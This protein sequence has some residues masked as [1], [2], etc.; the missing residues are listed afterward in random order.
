MKKGDIIFFLKKSISIITAVL[1]VL[2]C[3]CSNTRILVEGTK[4]I[5]IN[6][7][8]KS[9]EDHIPLE[10]KEINEK[11]QG[12][13]KVGKPYIIDNIEYIPKLVSYYNKKGIASWYGPKFHNKL[14]ANGEIFD[15]DKISAAHKTL[16][17]PSIVKV[18]NL[19]TQKFLFIRVNDRGPFVNNRI[20]D[21]SKEAAIQLNMFKKGTEKVRVELMDT[22]PH[23]LLE[24]FLN[25]AYLEKY[26]NNSNLE[27]KVLSIKKNAFYL[28]LGAF[29]KAQNAELYLERIKGKL[30]YQLS[31]YSSIFIDNSINYL[32]KVLIG[33]YEDE[34]NAKF[35]ANKLLKL[36]YDTI[37]IILNKG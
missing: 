33:P 21:L 32:H 15:Q 30:D 5:I 10:D 37:I 29:K 19:N 28:Q 22:G 34:K 35:A 14:T 17:L 3:A 1:L 7:E 26:V 20:I 16:P 27:K 9:K 25:Q 36:G 6:D 2:L 23:L 11:T 13:Y 12:H 24:K 18:T 4:R 31:T 8:E